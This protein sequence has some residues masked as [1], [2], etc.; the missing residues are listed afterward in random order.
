MTNPKRKGTLFIT[1]ENVR[2]GY[3]DISKPKYIF[4]KKL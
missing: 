2:E 4:K 3:I 1:S